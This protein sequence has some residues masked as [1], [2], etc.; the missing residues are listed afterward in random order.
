VKCTCLRG[1]KL[2]V[3]GLRFTVGKSLP[4]FQKCQSG[5]K[6]LAYQSKSQ[7]LNPIPHTPN[8]IP[9]TLIYSTLIPNLQ[10]LYPNLWIC[11]GYLGQVAAKGQ[12]GPTKVLGDLHV[13][14]YSV[15]RSLGFR[16]HGSGF[17]VQGLGFRVQGLGFR[18]QGSGFRVQGSG[19][20]VHS[21]HSSWPT[22][23]ASM[24]VKATPNVYGRTP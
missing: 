22:T 2:R 20:R 23:Y 14:R 9:Y 5:C 16:V 8:P 15:Y 13:S 4:K 1:L 3:Q 19:F 10:G 6:N 18:V 11:R 7:T 21:R 24:S 12:L 17:R